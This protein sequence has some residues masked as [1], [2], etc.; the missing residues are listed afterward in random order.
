MAKQRIQKINPFLVTSLMLIVIVIS[1]IIYLTI[2]LTNLMIH[3]AQEEAFA[4]AQQYSKSVEEKFNKALFSAKV[5]AF[6]IESDIKF[7]NPS[8]EKI[9]EILFHVLDINRDFLGLWACFEPNAFDGKDKDFVNAPG[10]DQ[11]GRYIPYYN[12]NQNIINLTAIHDYED[13][14]KG[15]FY[16]LPKKTNQEIITEPFIYTTY[17]APISMI[18]LAV[19]VFGKQK[20]FIGVVGLD[21][22]TAN[23]KNFIENIVPNN[24]GWGVLISNKGVIVAHQDPS[25]VGKKISEFGDREFRNKILDYIKEGKVFSGI[26]Y[27]AQLKD[28]VIKIYVPIKIG[29]TKTPWSFSVSFPFNNILLARNKF[30]ESNVLLGFF[31]LI[32]G[33]GFSFVI[34]RFGVK[35]AKLE[36]EIVENEEKF[37]KIFYKSSTPMSI[38]LIND[39]KFFDINDAF[40]LNY[41]WT[42][43]EA[44]GKTSIE[45][46]L[47]VDPSDR[48]KLIANLKYKGFVKDVLVKMRAKNGKIYDTLFS[49]EKIIV[50][51]Q[52]FLLSTAYNIT[53]VKKTEIALRQS[54]KRFK[55]IIT[56]T[57]NIAVE[58][59]DLMGNVI[60]WNSAA[61]K[62]FEISEKEAVGK[63]I[64]NLILGEEEAINFK[65][66]LQEIKKTQKATTPV[67]WKCCLK[68][69]KVKYVISSITPLEDENGVLLFVCMD[70]DITEKKN[71]EE[72]VLAGERRMREVIDN[73]PFAAFIY[74]LQE[75]E[76]L[77][78]IAANKS[79][80]VVLGV[81]CQQFIGKTL[82]EAF[83]GLAKTNIPQAYKDVIKTKKIFYQ[84]QVNY[85]RENINGIY[86]VHAF[87]LGGNKMAVLFRD[88]TEAKKI[89]QELKEKED[90]LKHIINSVP[91]VFFQ[92]YVK[93]NGEKGLYYVSEHSKE[94]LGLDNSKL[95]NYFSEFANR[96]VLKDQKLFLDSINLAVKNESNWDFEGEFIRDDGKKMF[97]K[98]ISQPYKK[99][100]ELVF[101]GVLLDITEKKLM[102]EAVKKNE[103][104]LNSIFIA[105][106]IG[107]VFTKNRVIQ[108]MTKVFCDILGYSE[109]ELLG[110]S[111]RMI[112][113]DEAEFEKVGRLL[114]STIERTSMDTKWQRKDG[115]M[116]DVFLSA[117]PVDSNNLELGYTVTA[118]DVTESKKTQN[119]LKEK[120]EELDQFFNLSLDLLCIADTQGNF[121]KLNK[122]WEEVLGLDIKTLEKKKFLDFVHPD[123]LK[124][125]FDALGELAA[126]NKVLDFVNRYRSN[127]GSYRWIEWKSVPSGDKIYAAA[128]DITERKKIEDELAKEKFRA[129][130]YLD[131]AGVMMV[132]I[133]KDQTVNLI[134]Q[135]GCE[136]LHCKQEDVIG[137]NWFNSFLPEQNRE[138]VKKVF[139][140][141]MSQDSVQKSEYFENSILTFDNKEERLIAWHNVILKDE[142][143]YPRETLSSGEDITQ[144]RQ[145]ENELKKLSQAVEQSPSIVIITDLTGNLE[146]A[147]PKFFEI[148]GYSFEELKN[149]NMRI[150]K[151]GF[152]SQDFYKKMWDDLLNNQI[153]HGEFYNKKKDGNFYWE[154]A[155]IRALKNNQGV[156]THY[157]KVSEDISSR[158]KIEMALVT[159]EAKFRTIF[160]NAVEGIY[161]TTPSGKFLSVNPAFAKMFGFNSPEQMI[162]NV[163]DIGNQIYVNAEDRERLK[164]LLNKNDKVENFEVQMFRKDKTKI[165][166]LVNI[167]VVRDNKG[168]LLYFEGTNIE[169]TQRKE[170][171]Q[172]REKL[173]RELSRIN[174]E[175]ESIVYVTSHDLR[176][177]LIN[178]LGFSQNLSKICQDLMP[179]LKDQ[180]IPEDLRMQM[181]NLADKKIPMALNYIQAGGNKMNLLING[182]LEVSRTGKVSLQEEEINMNSF[183]ESIIKTMGFQ[184]QSIQAKV[185][186]DSCLP[187]CYGDKNKLNQ[188][189]SNIIDNAIKYRDSDRL[190]SIKISGQTVGEN[191]VFSI[192]DNGKGV[193]K[194][195][196]DKIWELFYRLDTHSKVE[197]EGVGLTVV[198]RIVE[199]HNGKIW[200]ESQEGVGSKFFV[201]IPIKK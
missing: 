180:R 122:Q 26:E 77:I 11:T 154:D 128:R 139:N 62:I 91:G 183:F 78:F 117:A 162:E 10:H 166:V 28:K 90:K 101:N 54:E 68:N 82:E 80:D 181:D 176:S 87:S 134:N 15:L 25:H 16:L 12:R 75:D 135:K 129:Q 171:E 120:T 21:Y 59:Y 138:Q 106:P 2:S 152:Q 199:R 193:A 35:Q 49:A 188:V 118:M 124:N 179:T 74:E 167:H 73:S 113:A 114:Y 144:K 110:K 45:L 131:V 108:K 121:R 38:S 61:E 161:Q 67:E 42:R 132:A 173:L 65:N 56:Y 23:L 127:D 192:S 142:N 14:E 174:K 147:N 164:E 1:M 104:T 69:G 99:D 18:S 53:E 13:A 197:G 93:S 96:L 191:V 148:T 36:K 24:K 3:D 71:A 58:I 86:E 189:F 72:L 185:E 136:V 175:L 200:M 46:G 165:W 41:E 8:R 29:Q 83:P 30:L 17:D 4:L 32:I 109:L 130:K 31:L 84:E 198:K 140:E 155:Y 187:M 95:D 126:Q 43:E 98:G 190:L 19:P 47:W 141:L 195:Y 150:L 20:E 146:Y 34:N 37:S 103:A 158:K 64:K 160:E 60:F 22:E 163:T 168:S 201:Q 66:V 63:N 44:V 184:I 48:E 125:T 7:T 50:G 100:N 196:Q 27:D 33:I 178:I 172:E 149:K 157:V 94:M 105:A 5:I 169:I 116:I 97:F 137:K 51:Q 81:S 107:M 52:E 143:G 70:I 6:E 85:N 182:L 57:P 92:F 177:P 112:Y 119:N 123:D 55:D 186:V 79:A 145:F 39:G 102:E 133:G 9:N 76:K 151:S 88:I 159:S 170:A 156:V 111:S 40:V 194:E 89:Q 153:W 115:A